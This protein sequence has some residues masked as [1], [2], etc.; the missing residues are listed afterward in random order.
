MKCGY[1]KCFEC[2]REDTEFDW[3]HE[4]RSTILASLYRRKYDK[5]AQKLIVSTDVKDVESKEYLDSL[6]H[7]AMHDTKDLFQQFGSKL[8][9]SDVEVLG[10]SI[11]RLGIFLFPRYTF[12]GS[13]RV[14]LQIIL[15]VV[16]RASRRSIPASTF[17][18][19]ISGVGLKRSLPRCWMNMTA[20]RSQE[21]DLD[22]TGR[23]TY[24]NVRRID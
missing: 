15:P 11:A 19:M 5:K 17:A 9:Q 13:Y 1:G 3:S 12:R 8:K 23:I 4:C 14:D 2:I 24:R 21:N 6:V 20:G 10:D 18:Y 22:D 16:R 7:E